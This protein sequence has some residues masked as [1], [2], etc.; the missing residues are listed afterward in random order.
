MMIGTF[1]ID[2]RAAVTLGTVKMCLEAGILPCRLYQT[3]QLIHDQYT[4]C[5]LATRKPLL[6]VAPTTLAHKKN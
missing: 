1:A 2:G 4:N 6:E 5:T 3:Q